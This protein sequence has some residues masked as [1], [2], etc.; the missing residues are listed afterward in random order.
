MEKADFFQ[1]NE[2]NNYRRV[3]EGERNLE[4][5]ANVRK[6]SVE[7]YQLQFVNSK[8]DKKQMKTLEANPLMEVQ[9]GG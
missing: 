8:T 9:E 1:S 2:Y 6:I 3:E 5:R 4:K 7:K